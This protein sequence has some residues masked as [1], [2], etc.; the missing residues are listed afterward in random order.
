MKEVDNLD[1]VKEDW[2]C[3]TGSPDNQPLNDNQQRN[4]D[5]FVDSLFEELPTVV[6][7]RNSDQPKE[8]SQVLSLQ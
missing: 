8:H 5:Y 4:C 6:R 7:P 3:E 1:S 2:V